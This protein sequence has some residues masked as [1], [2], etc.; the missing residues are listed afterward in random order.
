MIPLGRTVGL[1]MNGAVSNLAVFP[2]A[3]SA[4]GRELRGGGYDVVH[5]H[6]PNVPSV[7]LVRGRGGP[8]PAVGTF[9]TY[10]TNAFA[11]HLAATSSARAASTRS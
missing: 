11:N 1:P 4:L 7:E 9:H 6:E 8:A 3:I 2:E 5:V 10:S